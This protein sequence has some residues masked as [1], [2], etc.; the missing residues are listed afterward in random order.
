MS[1]VPAG[2]Q[3]ASPQ[4]LL[5]VVYDDENQAQAVLAAAIEARRTAGLGI[6][7]TAVVRREDDGRLSIKEQ[8]DLGMAVSAGAGALVGGLLG[9]IIGKAGLGALLGGA[10]GAGAAKVIDAGIPDARLQQLGDTLAAGSSA[11]AAI[12]PQ[13]A[14]EAARA[15]FA[16]R[17]GLLAVEPIAPGVAVNIPRTGI[18][19]VDTLAAQAGE[20]IKPYAQQA[21]SALGSVSAQAEEATRDLAEQARGAAREAADQ[22]KGMAAGS[23]GEPPVA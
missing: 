5:I 4:H 14:L 16:A 3:P 1:E 19:Q 22:V 11:V 21:A 18:E 17:G 23:E 2:A 15:F 8:D 13:Q 20:A 12:V 9:M 7:E 10:A 6:K